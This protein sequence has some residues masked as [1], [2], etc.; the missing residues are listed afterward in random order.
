MCDYRGRVRYTSAMADRYALYEIEKLTDRFQLAQGVP[1]GVKRSYN[2]SPTQLGSVIIRRDG[3]NILER[4]K[5][6]FIPATAKDNNSVFRYKTY[7]AKTDHIFDKP[8]LAESI[9][10]SRCLVPANGFYEW[11]QTS[12][13]NLPFYL[14]PTDQDL[15]A[16]AGIY[17]SWTD[18]D[19]KV[20]GTYAIITEQ[21]DRAPTSHAQRAVI[22]KPSD[23]AEWLDPTI[24]NGNSI[25]G[26][27]NSTPDDALRIHR[28]SPDVKNTK[29]NGEQLILAIE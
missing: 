17:S 27:V 29:A 28:V 13:G 26:L 21:Y 2:I 12:G 15:F 6:G 20:W 5:W 11:H 22:L 14:R 18:P 23:E 9:R 24:S 25:F 7:L 4:M 10:H 16:F 19:G 8:T 1:A 3:V